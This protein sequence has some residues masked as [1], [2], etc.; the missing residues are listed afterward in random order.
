MHKKIK[1]ARATKTLYK[2]YYYHAG[3]YGKVPGTVKTPDWQVS[4]LHQISTLKKE[5]S[6]EHAC[7]TKSAIACME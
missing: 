2:G 6:V 7:D 5:K 3:S 4:E 1:S